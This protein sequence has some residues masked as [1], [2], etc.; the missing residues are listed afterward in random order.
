MNDK[1]TAALAHLAATGIWRSNYEPP[2]LR[3]LWSLSLDVPPPH[4]APFWANAIVTGGIFGAGCTAIMWFAVWSHQSMPF[5]AGATI[6]AGAG[7]LF[8]VT[9]AAYYEYGKR[10]HRLPAWNTLATSP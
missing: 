1:R 8:G 7:A 3:L 2:L 4:F 10:K 6:G 5:A 9:M